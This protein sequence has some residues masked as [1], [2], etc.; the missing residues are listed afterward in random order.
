MP[1][2]TGLSSAC[3]R[4]GACGQQD[5]LHH[6]G[7][8]SEGPCFYTRN[9]G[10]N[11]LFF[12]SSGRQP[13]VS[14][15]SIAAAFRRGLLPQTDGSTVTRLH[16]SRIVPTTWPTLHRASCISHISQSKCR[17]SGAPVSFQV[18]LGGLHTTALQTRIPTCWKKG[19]PCASRWLETA[20]TE[21]AFRA[22]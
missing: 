16:V 8:N 3:G 13:N 10:S 15:S 21:R 22:P 2:G 20:S 12:E 7:R 19:K 18:L 6:H 14:T 5:C 11:D 17:Q 9:E 4:G 1:L